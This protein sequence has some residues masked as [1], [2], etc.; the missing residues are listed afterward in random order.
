MFLKKENEWNRRVL[1]RTRFKMHLIYS[2]PE[3]GLGFP[4]SNRLFKKR[5]W[6]NELKF[7]INY[8]HYI[9]G[10][11]GEYS[12]KRIHPSWGLGTV[13]WASVWLWGFLE[14][15]GEAKKLMEHWERQEPLYSSALLPHTKCALPRPH[16]CMS[17]SPVFCPS[18]KG[19]EL[20]IPSTIP[21]PMEYR[22]DLGLESRSVHVNL[23]F[24]MF[25]PT[26]RSTGIA[27]K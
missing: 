1:L 16:Q 14:E 25:V 9:L 11:W 26:F 3:R 4:P 19:P 13:M 15:L 8:I 7:F 27:M 12:I 2:Y 10:I 20:L 22:K 21:E 24:W 17:N 5:W 18:L 23:K 6:G